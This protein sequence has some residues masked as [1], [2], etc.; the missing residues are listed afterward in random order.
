MGKSFRSRGSPSSPLPLGGEGTVAPSPGSSLL[1][2]EV[3]VRVVAAVRPQEVDDDV[4]VVTPGHVDVLAVGGARDVVAHVGEGD[5]R[6][7]L[8]ER[9]DAGKR[10]AGHALQLPAVAVARVGD[11]DV[12]LAVAGGVGADL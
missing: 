7:E 10:P 6:V 2:G 4:A 5:Q 8:R 9:V 3:H 1:L 11:E 12:E